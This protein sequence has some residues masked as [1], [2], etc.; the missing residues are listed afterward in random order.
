MLESDVLLSVPQLVNKSDAS[1]G[2]TY[3]TIDEFVRA[4]LVKPR[5][6][7]HHKARKD[8]EYELTDIGKMI[9]L[10][11]SVD[12][13]RLIGNR[14]ADLQKIF[15]PDIKL[16]ILNYFLRTVMLNA[17]NKGLERYVLRFVR[18]FI[19]IAES[20]DEPNLWKIAENGTAF[21]IPSELQL[22]K[23]AVLN[24]F[25]SLSDDEKNTVTQRIKNMTINIIFDHSMYHGNSR[26]EKLATM[27]QEDK[28]GIYMGFECKCGYRNEQLYVKMEDIIVKTFSGGLEC[29]KCGR[30]T[31]DSQTQRKGFRNYKIQL[32]AK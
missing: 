13:K 3:D 1:Y 17:I 15:Q 23:E 7:A 29:P 6:T 4:G 27:S 10:A 24:A 31:S 9:A 28:D 20:L 26:L 25:Y 11:V 18:N 19:E 2:F 21:A 12:E 5:I 8:S 14:R 16:G 22:L 32:H 30:L